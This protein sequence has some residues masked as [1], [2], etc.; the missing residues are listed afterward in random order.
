METPLTKQTT[1]DKIKHLQRYL[2]LAETE[3]C[4]AIIVVPNDNI[5]NLVAEEFDAHVFKPFENN[6][7]EES[8]C[9]IVF[10]RV[11]IFVRSKDKYRRE[12]VLKPY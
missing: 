2:F 3:Q 7:N 4:T 12:T 1:I 6:D 8:F 9:I 5:L 10:D 11:S